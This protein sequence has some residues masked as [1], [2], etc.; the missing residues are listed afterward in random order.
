MSK[1]PGRIERAIVA[2]LDAEPDNAFTTDD[3]VDRV[4]RGVN[5]IEKKH[6]V[7]AS[8]AARNVM[9]RR[10]T[11][12][13]LQSDGLGGMSVYFNRDNVLSYAMAWLKAD[14][15]SHYRSNDDRWF[16]P[17]KHSAWFRKAMGFKKGYAYQWP[18]RSEAE[19]RAQIAE[20]GDHHHLVVE[21][22]HWW[23]HTQHA[24]AKIEATRA[25]DHD[26]L[27][28]LEVAERAADE[29]L[30]EAALAAIGRRSTEDRP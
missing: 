26:R 9:K 15:F 3:L 4:Y 27:K 5:R 13:R 19:L 11:I 30:T 1:G 12:G 22:G 23:R 28:Q 8:R 14:H 2:I 21:G 18:R 10:D 16:D 6:R 24:I 7:A 17:S 29:A 25:G 20:G